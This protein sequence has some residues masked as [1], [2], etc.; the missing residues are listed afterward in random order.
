MHTLTLYNTYAPRLIA[1]LAAV[2][3]IAVFLYGAL[4]LGAVAHTAGRTTAE[5]EVRT[6][7]ASISTLESDFLTQTKALSPER[8]TALGFVTPKSITTVY[9]GIGSLTLR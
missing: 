3:G 4:L 1:L 6:V 7:S 2:A 5:R 9:A 8:A